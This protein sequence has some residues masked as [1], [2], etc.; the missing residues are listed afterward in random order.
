MPGGGS[1][2]ADASAEI[3]GEERGTCPIQGAGRV[4]AGRT[5][6]ETNADAEAPAKIATPC[7]RGTTLARIWHRGHDGG[8][9]SVAPGTV[10]AGKYRVTRVL[11]E[12]GMGVVVAATH[13]QLDEPVALKFMLPSALGS[14]EA[15]ARFLREARSA[16]KLKSEHVAR[17]SDVGTLDTGA[18]YIVMEYLEGSD[19]AGELLTRGP[20]PPTDTVEYVVQACD[21]LA[22]A[23]ALGI[24]H[25]D[26]KPANL[27]VTRRRDGSPLVKV[28]DFGISKSSALNEVGGGGSLTKTGGLMGS[29]VYMSPEQMKS[30]KD[31]DARTDIWALGIILYELVGGRTPFES[32]TLG[33]IRCR[34]C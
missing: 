19:L 31:T 7:A 29:P 2:G 12:G 4:P 8:V 32:E 11:G 18:P 9:S 28:L 20:L 6:C 3:A 30:A 10:L 21:A 34:R 16:V 27:F 13:I 23:H 1:H 15:I 24:V 26:L 17:V 33:G 25:R 14:T 22:E 5:A